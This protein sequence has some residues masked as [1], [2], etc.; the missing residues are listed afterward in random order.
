[1]VQAAIPSRF[2]WVAVDVPSP[3]CVHTHY[4]ELPHHFDLG[5]ARCAE[6][7]WQVCPGST[8][9][10][11]SM[12]IVQKQ[13]TARMRTPSALFSFLR[14][15]IQADVLTLSARTVQ[16]GTTLSAH[17]LFPS[18]TVLS[19]I[20]CF[21]THIALFFFLRFLPPSPPHCYN[22]MLQSSHYLHT[23]RAMIKMKK[24]RN[25]KIIENSK[26]KGLRYL[27]MYSGHQRK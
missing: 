22:Y 5:H 13:S 6:R 24:S 7:T 8:Q 1:M 23:T 27:H 25:E 15:S 16:G 2:P 20:I 14:W 17:T 26:T 10:N 19:K 12:L 3:G 9:D 18:P 21:A 11:S 4:P